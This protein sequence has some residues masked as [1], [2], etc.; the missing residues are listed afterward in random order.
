MVETGIP[1][2]LILRTQSSFS[3]VFYQINP[4]LSTPYPAQCVVPIGIPVSHIG[5][6]F[7]PRCYS[8]GTWLVPFWFSIGMLLVCYWYAV[9]TLVVP[10]WYPIGTHWY[11]MCTHLYPIGTLLLPNWY[12]VG[13]ISCICY[14][15]T[16]PSPFLP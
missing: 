11:P 6:P 10:H 14:P 5:D 2:S 8:S 1:T 13:T 9:G 3:V 15:P 12:P 16:L 7:M 4:E